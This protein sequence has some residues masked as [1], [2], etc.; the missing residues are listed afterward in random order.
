[1]RLFP[2]SGI[3]Y[4][5]THRH[6]PEPV[7]YHKGTGRLCLRL[8]RCR[9]PARGNSCCVLACTEPACCGIKETIQLLYRDRHPLYTARLRRCSAVAVHVSRGCLGNPLRET[10]GRS[11][12][13]KGQR[14]LDV[15][16][17]RPSRLER[18]VWPRAPAVALG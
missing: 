4:S 6:A 14:I 15:E 10:V 9:P 13:H 5:K 17:S 11:R 12:L 8:C 3:N 16:M 1:M 18:T 2:G 7:H